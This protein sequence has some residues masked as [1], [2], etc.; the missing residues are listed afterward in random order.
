M[1]QSDDEWYEVAMNVTDKM[2]GNDWK[3][4]KSHA[5]IKSVHS[6]WLSQPWFKTLISEAVLLCSYHHT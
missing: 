3:K 2:I 5:A 4:R 6:I 1:V